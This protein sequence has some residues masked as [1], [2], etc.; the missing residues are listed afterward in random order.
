MKRRK[1]NTK[2]IRIGRCN[3]LI[4]YAPREGDP[5]AVQGNE[6]RKIS[7]LCQDPNPD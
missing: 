1:L 7:C 6:K 3:F 4:A 5:G 2:K